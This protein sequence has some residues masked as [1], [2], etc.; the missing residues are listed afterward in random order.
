MPI[1]DRQTLALAGR[2]RIRSRQ[3]PIHAQTEWVRLTIARPT[4]A[5]PVDYPA[6]CELRISLCVQAGTEVYRTTDT[7]R[8]G[9][10]TVSRR[11]RLDYQQATTELGYHLPTGFFGRRSGFP[12]RLGEGR[13]AFVAWVEIECVRGSCNTTWTLDSNVRAAPKDKFH[14][15]IAFDAASSAASSSAGNTISVTHTATGSDRVAFIAVLCDGGDFSSSNTATYDGNAA[16]ALWSFSD[17]GVG[18]D[19]LSALYVKDASLGSGAKSVVGTCNGG[20][21]YNV[22][23]IGVCSLTGVDQTTSVGT[24]PSPNGNNVGGTTPSVTV[25]SPASDDC[26]VDVLYAWANTGTPSPGA[27]QTQR[28][29]TTTAVSQFFLSMSTQFGS[30]GGVMSWTKDT[31]W[32]YAIGATPFKAAAGGGGG[33]T[34][35]QVFGQGNRFGGDRIFSGRTL[36]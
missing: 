33:V 24:S 31:N 29:P 13:A 36:A 35:G 21:A 7:D 9:I 15:S 22:K 6:D 32:E 10:K 2:A 26:I 1:L 30:D 28:G 11:F 12:S 23:A 14:S 25:S 17:A 20:T 4:D 8:G 27:N 34:G 16:T 3:A 5:N 19:R 18:N